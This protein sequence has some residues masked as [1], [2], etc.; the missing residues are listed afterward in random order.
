VSYLALSF[1]I[2]ADAAEV[3]ADA[4]MDSGALSVDIADARAET[5][6]EAPL[7]GEPGMAVATVWPVSRL[8]ALFSAA[9]GLAAA[10]AA[11]AASG[12]V[13]P[14]HETFSVPEQDWVRATQAQFT[15]LRITETLWIVPSWC[16]PVDPAA[17]NL[18]LDPGLAF[19]T[20]SHPTTRLCLKWLARELRAGETVLDYGCGS[21]ILAIA[22]CRLGAARVVG[23]DVDPQA[24]VASR[25]NAKRNG[26]EAAFL[27]VDRLRGER[28]PFDVVVANILANP[29]VL[30]APA[31]ARRVR[32]GGRI[33][34]SGIL[35]A[36][37]V[38]VIA[39]YR[40]WFNI[41]ICDGDD[42]WVAL[43]GV[44]HD[45]NAVR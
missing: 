26:V 36:Q 37:A 39:A 19:G 45:E 10:L 13:L 23:T 44:R 20:G 11:L 8:T 41:A 30:L 25:A 9:T 3:W 43:A 4:L 5:P 27:R 7:Y 2:D 22:A 12:K 35:D 34:L 32:P 16:E 6:A 14:P 24:L 33:V 31:L 18:A 1:D 17:I 29:L 40:R 21:G 15:P 38:T 42:G 28:M